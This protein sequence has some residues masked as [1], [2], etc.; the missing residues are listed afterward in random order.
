MQMKFRTALD[1]DKFP[2]LISYLT[3]LGIG[4]RAVQRNA[5]LCSEKRT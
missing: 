3:Q 4:Y 5:R 1:K 2:Q